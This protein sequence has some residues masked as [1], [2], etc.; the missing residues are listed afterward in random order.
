MKLSSDSSLGEK[1]KCVSIL[2]FICL[3]RIID[4]LVNF[5]YN[6][7]LEWR[8]LCALGKGKGRTFICLK[9]SVN[10]WHLEMVLQIEEDCGLFKINW[11]F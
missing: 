9:V 1:F 11:I 3:C 8:D 10:R 7:P 4:Y 5:G 6:V 2:V